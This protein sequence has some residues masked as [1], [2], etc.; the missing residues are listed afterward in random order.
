MTGRFSTR[1]AN[2]RI[3]FGAG[4]VE[5]L[6]AALDAL[7]PAPAKFLVVSTSGRKD[8]A[9]AIACRL[10]GR[11]AGTPPIAR[12]HVPIEV[13]EGARAAIRVL[14]PEIMRSF[15]RIAR[16]AGLVGHVH[17]EQETPAMRACWHAAEGAVPYE[18]P[19]AGAAAEER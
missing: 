18:P 5:R 11:C 2:T 7:T 1:R 17:E 12:E 8:D 4:S 3:V 15:S 13:V 10:G 19:P 6:D 16:C 14:R 9:A